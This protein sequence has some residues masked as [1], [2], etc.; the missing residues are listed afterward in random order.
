MCARAAR[1]VCLR[2]RVEQRKAQHLFSSHLSNHRR[3]RLSAVR[4][5]LR[6][7]PYSTTMRYETYVDARQPKSS[8]AF[9]TRSEALR[10]TLVSLIKPSPQSS[11][12]GRCTVSFGG[13]EHRPPRKVMVIVPR[14]GKNS[15]EL[16]CVTRDHDT[17]RSRVLHLGLTNTKASQAKIFNEP[18]RIYGSRTYP[19]AEEGSSGF[20]KNTLL[21][22]KWPVSI[23]APYLYLHRIP[24]HLLCRGVCMSDLFPPSGDTIPHERAC[25]K[26]HPGHY[27]FRTRECVRAYLRA[28][29]CEFVVHT[30][31]HWHSEG[32]LSYVR[33]GFS[34]PVSL[35]GEC[36]VYCRLVAAPISGDALLKCLSW[37]LKT[38]LSLARSS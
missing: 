38:L 29:P 35:C 30:N 9:F 37:S 18:P 3:R 10:K 5:V 33:D 11:F 13:D 32:L 15:L 8:P 7:L 19:F 16:T 20:V 21:S 25:M 28:R 22:P 27:F 2:R 4:R 31:F 23:A 36:L 1:R 24:P 34:V 17:K 14:T 6:C 26:A 12:A